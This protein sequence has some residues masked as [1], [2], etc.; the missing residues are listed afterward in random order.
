MTSKIISTI[1]S[2]LIILLL[3]GC[4]ADRNLSGTTE[5]DLYRQMPEP[6]G[7]SNVIS[8]QE[9]T[10]ESS[11]QESIN[12]SNE[13]ESINESNEQ[14]LTYES[15]V[16]QLDI[17]YSG[18]P[19]EV[20][21]DNVPFFTEEEKI[22]DG[23]EEYSALDRLG[24]CGVAYANICIDVMPVESRGSI[25]NIRPSGWHTVKYNDLIDGNYLY[26]RCHLIAFELAGENANEK[27]LI[28]GTRY[29]NVVG[30]LP[31]EN[32]VADY[33]KTTQHHVL[34]RVTPVFTDDNLVADGVLMEA[35]SVEDKG[36]GIQFCVYA[37]NVQPGIEIDYA[38]GE[39]RL[40]N[41]DS[42]M[43]AESSG[44]EEEL[45]DKEDVEEETTVN[46]DSPDNDE[47]TEEYILNTNT[48]K[49]HYPYCRSVD[50]MKEE[51][52]QTVNG[53][54]DEIIDMGYTPCGNCKP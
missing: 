20:V 32:K 50:D 51:N 11:E 26:N 2:V 33:V 34:Y 19:Y 27:N 48:H 17:I 14:E 9:S 38:T 47:K 18:S 46:N 21:H 29:M 1:F 49:F 41:G 53:T 45:P 7:K 37:F 40:R 15:A 4:G 10:Y 31:F 43:S 28:T 22:V 13:Q 30:M 35:Y 23:F 54:R 36:E 25:G 3:N 52:K 16:S 6:A 5:D 24:R 8:E 42:V 12:E 39:S 44:N